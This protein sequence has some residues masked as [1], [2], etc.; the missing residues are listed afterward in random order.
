MCGRGTHEKVYGELKSG[1]AF[2]CIP[3]R[4]FEANSAWQ[5]MSI[6]AFNLTRAFQAMT[7]T[8]RR[9]SNRKRRAVIRFE[10]ITTLRYRFINR[11]ALL[12]KPNGKATLDVGEQDG[13]TGV[14][15]ARRRAGS[16]K[17]LLHQG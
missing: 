1:F 17:F 9:R 8:E 6:L 5:V 2:N 14:Q 3:T 4:R 12:V 11:A 10:R 16:M 13:R 7:T 15:E